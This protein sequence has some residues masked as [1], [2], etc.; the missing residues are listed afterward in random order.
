[1]FDV[2]MR[3]SVNPM[4]GLIIA[5]AGK[6]GYIDDISLPSPNHATNVN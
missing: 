2:I 6:R 4:H 1:M 3:Q 5:M